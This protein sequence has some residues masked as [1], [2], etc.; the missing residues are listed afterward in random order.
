M[1]FVL[2]A[3]VALCW[4][5][6]YQATAQADDILR[7]LAAGDEAEVS[8]VW[9]L[10]VT[11]ALLNAERRDGLPQSEASDFLRRLDAF[12]ISVDR[13][14]ISHSFVRTLA[15]SRERRLS[16][17][18][19]SYL[20]LAMRTRLPLATLDRGLRRASIMAGVKVIPDL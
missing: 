2:D 6:D 17:Y 15:I 10:E 14:G 16:S 5:L 18:D 1:R 8:F 19:A 20:E 7:G 4:C 3:S 9:P 11:N 12:S 13:E